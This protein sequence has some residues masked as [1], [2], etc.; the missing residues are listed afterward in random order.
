MSA[1]VSQACF[2]CDVTPSSSDGTYD[3]QIVDVYEEYA[4]KILKNEVD[5][6][7]KSKF[8]RYFM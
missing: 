4:K 1:F 7:L 5:I 6:H 8:T 3:S 2:S